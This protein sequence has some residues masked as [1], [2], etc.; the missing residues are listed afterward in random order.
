MRSIALALGASLTW[1]VSDFFGPLK[2]RTL[3]VLRVLVYVQLGGLTAIALIVAIRGKGPADPAVLFAVPAAISGTLGFYAYYRG[4]A[5]GAMSIVAPI[6]GISAAIPVVVGIVSGDRPSLWQWLGIAAALGGVFLASREPSRGGRVAAGVGLALLAAIGFGGYFP[7]MH[8]AGNAD[9]W[10][11]SLIFRMT[12]T[13]VILAA[14]AIRRPSLALAPIQVPLI[15]LIGVGDM[16]GNFLFAAASTSGLVSITSVLASLYPIV[17]VLLARL[18]L[19]ERV[20]RSQEAGIA[21][22]L[23]G[24][25]LISAG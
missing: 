1:G 11:A 9:F 2:G 14:V 20:A 13:S 12:S 7:P 25:A 21:L 19:K 8:T 16:L 4:M 24:V 15:A 23:A 10:W 6:A 22:T 17:T 3:G 5:V 18:V